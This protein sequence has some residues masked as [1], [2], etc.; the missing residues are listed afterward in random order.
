MVQTLGEKKNTFL[1]GKRKK[2]KINQIETLNVKIKET[3]WRNSPS[4]Y[5]RQLS[6]EVHVQM[7]RSG[8]Q[9]EVLLPVFSPPS[10]LGSTRPIALSQWSSDCVLHGTLEFHKTYAGVPQVTVR[11]P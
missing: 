6:T 1:K 4:Q 10:K 2:E 5:T 11:K 9:S 7:S 8:G 3:E